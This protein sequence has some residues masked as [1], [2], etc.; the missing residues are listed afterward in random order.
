MRAL[1]FNPADRY[2]SARALLDDLDLLR[3][4]RR[5]R[6]RLGPFVQTLLDRER[7][8]RAAA[9]P[10]DS[11][12]LLPTV[13][14]VTPVEVETGALTTV[15]TAQTIRQASPIAVVPGRQTGDR[16][17]L[18]LALARDEVTLTTLTGLTPIHARRLALRHVLALVACFC[19]AGATP[20]HPRPVTGSASSRET[21]SAPPQ[22][23]A[24]RPV[25]VTPQGSAAK[26][27]V[28]RAEVARAE[29]AKAIGPHRRALAP[30]RSRRKSA[31]CRLV[32]RSRPAVEVLFRGRNLGR[33][34]LRTRLPRRRL[35]LTLRNP[36]LGIEVAREVDARRPHLELA[37][38][39]GRGHIA[40]DLAPGVHVALD[41]RALGRPP[42]PPVAAYE[43]Q[44]VAVI[45]SAFRYS[46]RRVPVRVWPGRTTWVTQPSSA[47]ED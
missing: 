35:R 38:R 34:P 15:Q 6:P 31:R 26:A 30:R 40:F 32:L 41:G 28:A 47:I 27:E 7:A 16:G 3:A 24:P 12:A 11:D 2:P 21:R 44:H 4:R 42:L 17:L 19:L 37:I 9:D 45:T 46:S 29:V 14:V 36:A 5:A 22:T 33:T 10:P 13:P 43:G 1:A 39:L 20:W 23:A 8:A 18:A 25:V